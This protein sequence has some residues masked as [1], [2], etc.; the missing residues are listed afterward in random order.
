MKYLHWR[1]AL[2]DVRSCRFFLGWPALLVAVLAAPAASAQIAFSDVSAFAGVDDRGESYG[3][4]WG[5]LNGDGYLDLFA[6]NHRNIN[7]LFLNMK[8]GKFVDIATQVL[9]WRNR[10]KADTHGATWSD[11]D[12]DGDQDILVSTGTGNLSQF[13][14]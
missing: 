4:S 8:N 6:S 3:A 9:P 2:P 1:D 14:R 11:Y 13:L 7:S 12:N 10:P 5:D